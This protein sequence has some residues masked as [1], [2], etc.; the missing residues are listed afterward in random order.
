M[1]VAFRPGKKAGAHRRQAAHAAPATQSRDEVCSIGRHMKVGIS[2][3]SAWMLGVGGIIGSMAWLFHS[4]LIARAGPLCAVVAWL[5]GALAFVPVTLILA[6]LSSMFPAAGGPYLYKYYAF[7]RLFK[8]NGELLGFLTGWLFYACL[9][10]GYACMSCG[11]V[12]LLAGHLYGGVE[13]SPIWFGPLVI[14][15]LFTATTAINL[16]Q[17]GKATMLNNVFTVLKF[18]MVIAFGWVV[19]KASTSS[20]THLLNPCN[21][22]G[23]SNVFANLA[24]ILTV[25]IG[26]YGGIELVA[27]TSSETKEAKRSVPRAMFLTLASVAFIYAG[28]CGGIGL[29]SGWTLSPDKTTCLVPGTKLAAT[30]PGVI[31]FIAG[32]FWGR[33]AA[34]CVISSIV[35]CAIAGLLAMARIG[36][37]LACTGLFPRHFAHLD[38]RTGVPSYSLWFQ[39]IGL[40]TIGLTAFF[41]SRCGVLPDAYSFLAETFCFMYLF[42]L[43]L[44]G[45]SLMILRYTDPDMP[46]P[47]RIG[48]RGNW[49][50]WLITLVATGL[51]GF[52]AFGC[53]KPIY[54]LGG[55]I[56]LLSGLPIYAYFKRRREEE[57]WKREK[58]G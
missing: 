24:G 32:S 23:Q 33:V 43:L 34:A 10:A 14:V 44:Y 38:E 58:A 51:F 4:Y 28:I 12:N 16:L 55:L 42:V 2:A 49:L 13:K 35:G 9:L 29:A 31:E 47:Y 30:F 26:G 39:F 53:T 6:E 46:R 40:C 37:S 1:V 41:L 20:I 7:K 27:C 8:T 48:T 57:G 17:V 19:A 22:S 54:Q 15:G 50:A 21:L 45:I 18:V 11:L 3:F 36:Y 56:I 5:L 52:V 25:T